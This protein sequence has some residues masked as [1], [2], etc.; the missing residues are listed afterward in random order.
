[1]AADLN[2]S[3][4]MRVTDIDEHGAREAWARAAS[5]PQGAALA[6]GESGS[7]VLA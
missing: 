6:I 1:L 4:S 5:G 7:R 2:E 3:M